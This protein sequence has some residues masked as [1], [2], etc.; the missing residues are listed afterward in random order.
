MTIPSA[1]FD[2]MLASDKRAERRLFWGEIAILAL[3]I[4]GMFWLYFTRS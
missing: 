3:V 4:G 2:Q 1:E